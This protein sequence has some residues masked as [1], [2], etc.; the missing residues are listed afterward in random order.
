M[1][2][3]RIRNEYGAVIPASHRGAILEILRAGSLAVLALLLWGA[4][5]HA[6]SE[7]VADAP[8]A[9]PVTTVYIVRHAEKAAAG[10]SDP[11][12]SAAGE[13]RADELA[14]V[15]ADAG[16]DAVFVTEFRRT[17]QTGAPTAAAAGVEPREY[18]AGDAAGLAGTIR[19]GS[20]G[21]SV[22]VVA[23]SNTVDDVAAALGAPGV[24]ELDESQYDRLF[25]VH[26][27]SWGSHLES[28]RYGH[29][30]P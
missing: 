24:R 3:E 11:E 14:H 30:T 4:L 19:R 28:L 25:V 2:D 26:F 15:L 12:L 8:E 6:A 9:E 1:T 20:L 5:A 22:L 27:G 23:H 17:R 18:G 7:Q 13:E 29:E 21:G 10:G 16:I